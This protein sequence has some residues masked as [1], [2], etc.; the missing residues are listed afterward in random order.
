VGAAAFGHKQ[1]RRAKRRN[2]CR[3]HGRRTGFFKRKRTASFSPQDLDSEH[4]LKEFTLQQLQRQSRIVSAYEGKLRLSG[5]K[6]AL[7]QKVVCP[8]F[9][10]AIR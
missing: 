1:F 7:L 4:N 8:S 9:R 3:R 2:P 6:M 10:Y 5:K